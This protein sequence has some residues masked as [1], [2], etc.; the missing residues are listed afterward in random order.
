MLELE[1]KC[2]YCKESLMDKNHTICDSPSV[3]LDIEHKGKRG[4][5]HLCARY[6]NYSKDSAIEI[7]EGEVVQVTCSH[8]HTN[9]ESNINCSKCGAPMVEMTSM[10]GGVIKICSRWGCKKHH[11]E[12]EDLETELRAFYASYSLFFTKNE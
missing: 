6:G 4:T 1:L 3:E 10:K 2:P 8:C 9:L 11:L 7:P 12:F 5:V